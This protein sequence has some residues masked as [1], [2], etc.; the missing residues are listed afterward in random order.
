MGRAVTLWRYYISEDTTDL[1]LVCPSSKTS[2]GSRNKMSIHVNSDVGSSFL[3]PVDQ[4]LQRLFLKEM[5]NF[6]KI[7]TFSQRPFNWFN[8]LKFLNVE[9]NF[10]FLLKI[11]IS[12]PFGLCWQGAAAKFPPFPH[13]PRLCTM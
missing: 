13:Q 6:K 5:I 3:G 12:S 10:C 11:F 7:K 8:N 2:L 1:S 9:N 4:K